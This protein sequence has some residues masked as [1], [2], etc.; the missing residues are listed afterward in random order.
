MRTV[1]LSPLIYEPVITSYYFY[2]L[3][4]VSEVSRPVFIIR[5]MYKRNF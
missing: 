5:M 3:I 2:L 1:L 4:A